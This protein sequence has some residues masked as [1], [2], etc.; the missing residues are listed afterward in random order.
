MDDQQIRLA[1]L[2][3]A[4]PDTLVNPDGQA[5]VERAKVFETYVKGDVADTPDGPAAKRRST[6]HGDTAISAPP[7]KT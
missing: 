5:I 1:C 6:R 4:R 2:K 7:T 3:L